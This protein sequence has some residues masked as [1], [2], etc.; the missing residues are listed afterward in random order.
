M[1]GY[2]YT[3]TYIYS[4]FIFLYKAYVYTFLLYFFCTRCHTTGYLILGVTLKVEGN[5]TIRIFIAHWGNQN[6][7]NFAGEITETSGLSFTRECKQ[8]L[9]NFSL[10][11]HGTKS[12][13]FFPKLKFRNFPVSHVFIYTNIF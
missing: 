9:A 10:Q 12:R 3:Y 8:Y 11:E 2:I 5:D 4:L 7:S 13:K 6:F 1:Y